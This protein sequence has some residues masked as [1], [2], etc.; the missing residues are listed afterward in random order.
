MTPFVT[1]GIARHLPP[2]TRVREAYRRIAAAGRPEV[3][4]TLRCEADVTADAAALE[5]R[6]A[7]GERLPLAGLLVAVK[8]NI[9]VTSL[10]TTAACPEYSYQPAQTATAIDRLVRAGALV[11][12]QTNL[13]QFATGLVGTRSPY[14]AVRCA[15]DPT[16][17]SGGSSSGSAVAVG[18]GLVDIGVGTDTAGSGRVPAAFQGIVGLKASLGIV[19]TTGVVPACADY[20]CVTVLAADLPTAQRALAVMSGPDPADPRSR[21]WPADVRLAAP[22]TPRIAVPRDADLEELTPGYRVAFAATVDRLITD[23]A[24]VTEIDISELLQAATMLYDGAIVAER[25]TAVGEFLATSPAGADPIVAGIVAAA[26]DVTGHA[27]AADLDRLATIRGHALTALAEADA[28]L[29]PV[30]T[31]HPTIDA[32]TADPLGINRRLGTYTNFANLLDMAAIAIPSGQADGGPFGVMLVVPALHDHVA[33]DLAARI[34]G[35]RPGPLLTGDVVDLLVVGAHMRGQPLNG[36]LERIGARFLADV[37]TSDAYRMVALTTGTPKPGLVRHGTGLGAPIA[38]EL[39][40]TSAAG[41]GRFLADLPAPMGL[42]PVE[43]CDEHWVTGFCCSAE[44]GAAAAD[45][46]HHGGWRA[47]LDA[48]TQTSS[49][50]TH[51]E[52]RV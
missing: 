31:E 51:D 48:R 43:L 32:V 20:D 11:L 52:A 21:S 47:Y 39:W 46:T 13:D 1:P 45:I 9:D 24:T 42:G 8:D 3:W 25:H 34:T 10:P 40:Q 12:G 41:L 35:D 22:A 26:A 50:A 33:L 6:L 7:Q 36:D 18:L 37:T 49:S 15:W 19:P 28:L 23:G 14:G 27:F 5:Q 38:G 29:L 17:I 2:T 44:S 4:I 16:R 30:T